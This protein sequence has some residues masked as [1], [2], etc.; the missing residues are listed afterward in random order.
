MNNI[1][2]GVIGVAAI[3]FMMVVGVGLVAFAQMASPRGTPAA[4]PS[5]RATKNPTAMHH[6]YDRRHP[7][8]GSRPKI[9]NPQ[10]KPD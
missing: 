5:A 2:V 9:E 4:E 8:K 1:V 6:H 3:V 7:H 10:E